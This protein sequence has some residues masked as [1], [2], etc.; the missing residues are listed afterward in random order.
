MQIAEADGFAGVYPEHKHRIVAE[1]QSKGLLV[2]MTGGWSACTLVLSALHCTALP[3]KGTLHWQ[4]HN[5]CSRAHVTRS[6]HAMSW[7]GALRLAHMASS[8]IGNQT[9][10]G[11][12]TTPARAVAAYPVLRMIRFLTNGSLPCCR[13]RGE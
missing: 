12:W 4:L 1:M 3:A 5:P 7:V 8:V 11:K 9:V 10:T 13:R 2:G 6:V